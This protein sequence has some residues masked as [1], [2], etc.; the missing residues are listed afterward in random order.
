[1]NTVSIC[2][3]LARE[4]EEMGGPSVWGKRG[5]EGWKGV[6]DAK[7]FWLG[8]FGEYKTSE[9]NRKEREEREEGERDAVIDRACRQS[10]NGTG[11]IF[12]QALNT[13]R[14]FPMGKQRRKKEGKKTSWDGRRGFRSE[15]PSDVVQASKKVGQKDQGDGR[16]AHN[17]PQIL[18][19]WYANQYLAKRE[20]GRL[21]RSGRGGTRF[22][23]LRGGSFFPGAGRKGGGRGEQ[24]GEKSSSL[25]GARGA[26]RKNKRKTK[27][28]GD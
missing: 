25:C 22:L 10:A 13:N 14:P 24:G 2:H 4:K 28:R 26:G 11:V 15:N 5:R 20:E 23:F 17:F 8:G 18:L 21:R 27:G 9:S 1:V 6:P 16:C 3:A 19:Q 12:P 7:L